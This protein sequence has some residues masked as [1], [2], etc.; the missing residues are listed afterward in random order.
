[1]NSKDDF[2]P[3]LFFQEINSQISGNETSAYILNAIFAIVIMSAV[4]A[5]VIQKLL[6]L[7]ENFMYTGMGA[8]R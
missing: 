5:L 2:L 7:S 4:L 6:K 1:M 3:G 8:I